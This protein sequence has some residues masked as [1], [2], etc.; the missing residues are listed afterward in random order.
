METPTGK[1]RVPAPWPEPQFLRPYG[2]IYCL[3]DVIACLEGLMDEPKNSGRR[4]AMALETE[5]ALKESAKRGG[6]KVDL[7]L[8]DRSLGFNCDWFRWG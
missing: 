8:Q 1:K 5:I 6:H 7:P 3:N 4:V 2:G